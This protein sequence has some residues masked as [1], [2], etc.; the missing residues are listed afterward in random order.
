MTMN[1]LFIHNNFP[2]QY[3][4]IYTYLKENTDYRMAAATLASNEQ[5]VSIPRIN[6]TPHRE[7]NRKIHPSLISTER[8]VITGQAAY[9]ALL[10]MKERG[11]RPD[12]VLSHSGWGNGMFIKDIFPDA[13]LLNYYEW[14]YHCHGGDGEFLMDEPYGP[15]DEIRIRMKNTPILHDMVAQDWGQCPTRFQHGQLPDMVRDRISILHD[16]VDTDFFKPVDEPRLKL[17]DGR[18]LTRND[19]VIT[20]IARGMEEYRGFPQFMEMVSRLQKRRPRLQTVIIAHDRIAYGAQR[21]DGKGLKQWALDRFA[22]DESRL[23]F[24]GLQP[25]SFLRDAVRVARAHV[26]LTAPFVLSWSLLESMAAGA[27]I[28]GSDTEPVRE[29]IG[30]GDT[31]WLADFFDVDALM[32]RV[33]HAIDHQAESEPLRRAARALILDRYDA[34]HLVPRHKRL[35][36]AVAEGKSVAEMQQI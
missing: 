11:E 1:I 3:R 20:Y 17:P 33:D 34:K 19:E 2:G 32:D 25:L 9:K 16:G 5:R 7:P 14:Y 8:A 22:F 36:E 30:H 12:V 28:V 13:K 15:N 24:T 29:V 31:G 6:Y 4:R 26:Y 35:I 27:L 21:P 23:H 18:E 10:A